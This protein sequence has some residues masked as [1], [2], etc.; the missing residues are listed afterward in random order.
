MKRRNYDHWILWM[1]YN[2]YSCKWSDFKQDPLSINQSSLSNNL[3]SL[4]ENKF[5][6]RENKEYVIT[7]LGRTEYFTILKL[8]DM[9]RQSILEQESKRIEEITNKTREFFNKHKIKNEE[10]QFR[11]LDYVLKLNYSKVESILKDEEDFN[12]ILLFLSSNHPYQYPDYISLEDF[13]LKYSID[14]KTLNYYILEIVD[15]QFF[16]I[17][18]FKLIDKQTGIYYFQKGEP[19]EKI[20]NAIVEKYITK[21]Y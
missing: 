13:S 9:D 6:L 8:Y 12:K 1:V 2:N 11:Y 14:I 18:F 3:N 16:Q 7:P 10:L 5:V 19:L 15:N 20:L 17:K 21:F 4:I